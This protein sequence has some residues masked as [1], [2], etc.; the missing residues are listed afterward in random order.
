[1]LANGFF[2]LVNGKQNPRNVTGIPPFCS[3]PIYISLNIFPLCDKIS[4][5][6]STLINFIDM[7]RFLAISN[8][9]IELSKTLNLKAPAQCKQYPK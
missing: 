8:Y 4:N 7:Y 5:I 6:M 2:Y 9:D 1:M 3:K